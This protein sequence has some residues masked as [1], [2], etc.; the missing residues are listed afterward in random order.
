M[1]IN[2]HGG[3]DMMMYFVKSG[4]KV[5]IMYQSSIVDR[6]QCFLEHRDKIE[7]DRHR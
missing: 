4:K 7:E 3:F 5:G 1:I 6:E 2:N